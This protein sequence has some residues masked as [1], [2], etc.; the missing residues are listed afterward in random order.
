METWIGFL[1][2]GVA[3]T[4][5]PG[6]ATLSIAA[7][8]AAFGRRRGFPYYLGIQIGMVLVMAITASG[9]AGL[10]LALP[11]MRPIVAVLAVAYFAYLAFRIA[12]APPLSDTEA[13]R[14]APPLIAGVGLALINPKGY[15]AMAALFSGF[16]LV[17]APFADALAKLLILVAIIATVDLCWLFAGSALTRLFR[18]TARNRAVNVTFAALLV[19]SVVFA[20]AL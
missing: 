10:L 8:G 12:T 2:A 20:F 5:S 11:G 17:A 14:R 6:P 16:V 18:D 13:Q 19:V 9:A 1:M 7:T 15:A 4:G 3:L